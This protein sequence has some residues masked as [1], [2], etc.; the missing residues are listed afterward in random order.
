MVL[1]FSLN[2]SA[3]TWE[4]YYVYYE[5]DYSQGPWSRT[6]IL[7]QSDYKFLAPVM[8]E[9][10]FGSIK[11]GFVY[12][13]IERL[14]DKKP[15][16]YQW[17]YELEC[18]GDTVIFKSGDQITS[19]NTVK[20]E[21]VSSLALNGSKVVIFDLEDRK[22]SFSLNDVSLPY[23]DLVMPNQK[24]SQQKVTVPINHLDSTKSKVDNLG[25]IKPAKNESKLLPWLGISG[26]LNIVLLFMIKRKSSK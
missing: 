16:L 7:N 23:L 10:L 19:F 21:I 11:S 2:V 5:T 12:K 18:L 4:T 15:K 9:D 3:S 14:R 26:I 22:E 6:T 17:K 13:V 24:N 25:N 1:T 8:F 20:N